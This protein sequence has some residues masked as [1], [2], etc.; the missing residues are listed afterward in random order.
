MSKSFI[1]NAIISSRSCEDTC[2]GFSCAMFSMDAIPNSLPQG[3]ASNADHALISDMCKYV[4]VTSGGEAVG[5]QHELE[6]RRLY[7]R[8]LQSTYLGF[9][10]SRP[11]MKRTHWVAMLKDKNNFVEFIFCS[12]RTQTSFS[13]TCQGQAHHNHVSLYEPTVQSK[14]EIWGLRHGV[15]KWRMDVSCWL[16]RTSCFS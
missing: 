4:L 3:A 14:I 9:A 6:Q 15:K 10:E 11:A 13:V 7:A 5:G 2:M 1:C 8:K 12:N 16:P